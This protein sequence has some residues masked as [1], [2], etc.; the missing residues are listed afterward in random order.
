VLRFDDTMKVP[1]VGWNSV[2][3]LRG[4][5]F[6]GVPEGSFAYFAHSYYAE[7]NANATAVAHY[8][9]S[10]AAAVEVDN[11]QAVQF[12]PEKSGVIGETVLR[13]FLLP[14]GAQ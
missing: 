8:S 14:A 6:S 2:A 10:F 9:T 4:P 11:F 5:L 12:H 1:H 13:N 7:S 3:S